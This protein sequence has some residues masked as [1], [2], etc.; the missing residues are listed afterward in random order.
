MLRPLVDRV[1]II[2]VES[3]KTTRFHGVRNLTCIVYEYRPET[4]REY[5]TWT[6]ALQNRCYMCIQGHVFYTLLY[7]HGSL[8]HLFHNSKVRVI[9]SRVS[10]QCLNTIGQAEPFVSCRHT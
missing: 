6:N 2:T 4:N 5:I 10:G 7:L 9:N 8:I 3:S 1:F